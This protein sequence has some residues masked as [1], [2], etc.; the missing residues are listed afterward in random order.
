MPREIL[1]LREAEIRRLLDPLGCLEAVEAAL[2]AY[3]TGRAELPAVIQLDVPEHRGEIHIKAGHLHAGAHYA[4]KIVSG[5][6]GNETLGLPPSGGLVLAFDARTGH[7]RALLLDN[8]Y[9]TDLRTGA[10]GAVAAKHLARQ[11]AAVAAVIGT[12]AQA[13][14]QARA[15]A[16]V[17]PLVEIRVFGRNPEKAR[18]CAQ[19]I[20]A[21]VPSAGRLKVTV[22]GSIREAMSGADIVVT[23]TA[24]REPLVLADWVLPGMHLTAVGSDQPDKQELHPDVLAR[25]DVLVADSRPQC[26]RLGEIHHAV[27]Q[28]ALREQDIDAELGE[29]VAGRAP[30]RRG[31]AD[32]T[33][34]DLTGVG[35]QDVAAANVVLARALEEGAGQRLGLA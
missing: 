3:S 5:F 20:A 28:G 34:C 4:V 16:L 6:P 15:L 2:A 26:L 29:I 18:A 11:D 19:D 12:G 25:A 7:P 23:A 27:A 31:P 13:R 22:A 32:I 24:S 35:V 21:Q 30:G 14:H 17:R 10:A 1:V 9:I 33:V 8:G